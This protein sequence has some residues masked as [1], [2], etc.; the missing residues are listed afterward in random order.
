MQDIQATTSTAV[1]VLSFLENVATAPRDVLD[2][3]SSLLQT[4]PVLV[5]AKRL[6]GVVAVP[7]GAKTVRFADERSVH[8]QR[9]SSTHW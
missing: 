1:P 3:Y 4:K 7:D 2:F 8:N 6:I 5:D 9:I